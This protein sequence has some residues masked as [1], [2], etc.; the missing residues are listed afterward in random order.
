MGP[1]FVPP[2]SQLHTF[3]R[4]F[5][6]VCL[7]PMG[8]AHAQQLTYTEWKER[9]AKDLRL[10]PHYGDAEK[11]VEQR[12]ADTVFVERVMEQE[13][14]RRKA[15]DRLAVMGLALLAQGVDPAR[16]TTRGYGK[17]YPVAS[18]ATSSGRAQ[19]RRVEVTISNDAKP[20]APRSSV[21]SNY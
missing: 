8:A 18:N 15:S 17:D 21:N 14:D 7:L 9:V 19:N 20:V 6:L 5:L 10:L 16:V 3:M 2:M 13:P 1:I 4:S 12:I 11:T